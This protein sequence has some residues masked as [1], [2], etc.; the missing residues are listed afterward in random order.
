MLFF[1]VECLYGINF[2]LY[3]QFR[4]NNGA[5]WIGSVE[6]WM[7]HSMSVRD[8]NCNI[9]DEYFWE[10]RLCTKRECIIT[11]PLVAW[12]LMI[13]TEFV[14]FYSPSPHF[15]CLKY[16]SRSYSLVN[17]NNSI[18]AELLIDHRDTYE[19]SSSPRVSWKKSC[20]V[21]LTA[22]LRAFFCQPPLI[23]QKTA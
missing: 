4:W 8:Q 3:W 20:H 19:N 11:F 10:S 17:R 21:P 2:G 5:R 1:K 9:Q 14:Q 7:R 23:C 13:R 18:T 15:Q 6:W 12:R 22:C 16:L